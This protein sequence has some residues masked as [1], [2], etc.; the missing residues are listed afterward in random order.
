MGL[1][2]TD[3]GTDMGLT[4]MEAYIGTEMETDMRT[5]RQTNIGTDVTWGQREEQT[6]RDI[7]RK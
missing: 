5:D 4:D 6:Y 7:P 2:R 3:M 1:I